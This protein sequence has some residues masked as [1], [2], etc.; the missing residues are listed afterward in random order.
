MGDWPGVLRWL[1]LMLARASFTLLVSE[2]ESA[3]AVV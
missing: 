1:A 3:L 2:P